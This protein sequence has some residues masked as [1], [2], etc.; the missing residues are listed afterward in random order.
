M[1][2]RHMASDE[3]ESTAEEFEDD[4]ASTRQIRTAVVWVSAE[5]EPRV[6]WLSGQDE[7]VIGRDADCD[8]ELPATLVSRRHARLRRTGKSWFIQDLESR[9]GVSVNGEP[10][11]QA[12]IA[13]GDVIR[14]GPWIGLVLDFSAT[15]EP[16]YELLDEDLFGGP[17]L[18][19]LLNLIHIASENDFPVVLEGET[20]TG[21]EQFA[22]SIHRKSRRQGP[23][24]AINCAVYQPATAAAELFGYKRGAFTGAERNHPGLIRAAEG[25]TLLLDEITDLPLDVQGQLLRAIENREVIPLGESQPIPV[26]ARFLAATQQPLGRA[27]AE[28]RFRPDLRARL[29]GMRITMP[30]LRE[31]RGDIPFLFLHLL[32]RDRRVSLMPEARVLEEL[33]LYDW[34]LNVREMVSL[35][36]RLLAAHASASTLSLAQL[37]SALP[38]LRETEQAST[39]KPPQGR[40][41]RSDPRAFSQ[42]ELA[43]LQAALQ[44]HAGNVASAA[45]EIGISRQRVYRMLKTGAK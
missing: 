22:R 42:A 21:K 27:V 3:P 34:P 30:P 25:G 4:P 5:A 29:E 10:A 9:N 8:I 6:S 14:L 15:E 32:R 33:C 12:A 1:P 17:D 13:E 41:T 11:E 23:F 26:T 40:R 16:L 28:G 2:C 31:R 20:G 39:S 36:Q 45:A 18:R 35:V 37:L 43:E 24:L 7:L 19:A 38:E 44:R